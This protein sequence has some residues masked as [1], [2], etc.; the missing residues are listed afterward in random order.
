MVYLRATQQLHR[1]HDVAN[2][3][4]PVNIKRSNEPSEFMEAGD[5]NDHRCLVWLKNYLVS[6]YRGD[7][8]H[9]ALND[10]VINT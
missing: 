1:L 9:R 10:Q 2:D 8:G 4:R 6:M 3:K 5:K 7:C